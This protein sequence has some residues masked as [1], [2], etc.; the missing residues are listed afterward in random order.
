MKT[1]LTVSPEVGRWKEM[2]SA[3]SRWNRGRRMEGFSGQRSLRGSSWRYP[4]GP[5]QGQAG[6]CIHLRGAWTSASGNFR[7]FIILIVPLHPT[8]H[9]EQAPRAGSVTRTACGAGGA[10]CLPVPASQLR[11]GG[12]DALPGAALIDSVLYFPGQEL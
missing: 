10:V 2:K 3:T 9:T 7:D 5:L 4:G 11:P 8:A 1:S 6:H 12:Q